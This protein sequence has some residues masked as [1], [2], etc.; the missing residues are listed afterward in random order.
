MSGASQ[1]RIAT[2]GGL[3][4]TA[5]L[6]AW[7][8]GSTRLAL[9]Q[10]ADASRAAGD[11]LQALW[12]ARVLAVALLTPRVAA[13]HGWRQGAVNTLGL[14]APAW[15]LLVLAASASSMPWLPLALA[16]LLLLLAGGLLSLA[17]Q[18]LRRV[19]SRVH[20]AEPWSEM[21]G[22]A[23]GALLL[24]ALWFTRAAWSLPLS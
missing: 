2:A 17:G 4:L 1:N 3:L 11:A 7:W 14:V 10:G 23:L 12:L 9:D 20:R 24:A 15:P 21:G 5:V 18:G 16:D 22:T 6:A 8:L 19:L 13:L